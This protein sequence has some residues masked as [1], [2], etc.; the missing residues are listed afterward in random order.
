MA[1]RAIARRAATALVLLSLAACSGDQSLLQG[2]FSRSEV[3]TSEDAANIYVSAYPPVPWAS[4]SAKLA[5]NNNL[6]IDQARSMAAQTTQVQIEQALNTF[7]AG[8]AIGLP[9]TSGT[10]QTTG[11]Q[12]A[13][14]G[15]VPS[16]SGTPSGALPAN[17]PAPSLTSGPMATGI[18]ASTWLTAGTALYQQAQ[19]LDNQITNELLPEGYQAYLITFQINLQPK[20]RDLPYDAY[21][22]VTLFP[23]DWKQALQTSAQVDDSASGLPP[24]M[25]YPLIIMD[26]EETTN[27]GR[28]LQAIRQASLQLSGIVSGVGVAAGASGAR[29]RFASV[30]GLDKNSLVTIGRV[31]DNAV[32]V[33][34]GAENSGS[35]GLAM[36]PRSYNVSLVVLTR[37]NQDPAQRDDRLNSLSVVTNTTIVDLAG[38]PLSDGP[39]R[40]RGGLASKVSDEVK[41][42]C[43][44]SPSLV[45]WPIAGRCGASGP[46]SDPDP[47]QEPYQTTALN[48][49]RAVDRGDFMM[50][51]DC[52][53]LPDPLDVQSQITVQRL[54]AEL[55]ELQVD[56]RF[57]TFIIPLQASSEPRLPDLNQ[58]VLISDDGTQAATAVLRGGGGLDAKQVR[59]ALVLDDSKT[60]LLPTS[61]TIV[62]D[63]SEI[64]I[65][66][67]SI[68]KLGVK[69]AAKPLRFATNRAS[70]GQL[71]DGKTSADYAVM[72]VAATSPKTSNPVQAT[73]TV[74][75]A[76][77]GTR[78]A[79]VT[80]LVA[81]NSSARLTISGADIRGVSAPASLSATGIALPPGGGVITLT[82]GNLTPG[83]AVVTTTIDANK[84]PL[85]DPIAFTVEL[86]TAKQ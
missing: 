9:G 22:D 33:R 39:S 46:G 55:A 70:F 26:A 48:L 21:T 15:T 83:R 45:A 78:V 2:L 17:A 80:L 38:K 68:K 47:A 69:L 50:V 85:G 18:D 35:A 71:P 4:I 16:T 84:Q 14:T 6:T 57:S 13:S 66:F 53:K 7:A 56:S 27:I 40:T 49:L 30:V 42:F 79:T 58:L 31:N 32:R 65:A 23:G 86:A 34:L 28:S 74:L 52:L 72:R 25:V 1:C 3:P 54:L 59:A 76:G 19:V 11:T 81:K 24:V 60:K 41:K 12:T 43:K 73:Q 82:L 5:P 61:L 10:T 20:R 51:R 62:G 77:A 75:T 8:L 29:D 64:D 67:P 44:G 63:G 37:W 36:V